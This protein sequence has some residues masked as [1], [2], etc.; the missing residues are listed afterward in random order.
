MV[1]AFEKADAAVAPIY[2]ASQLIEDPQVR[3]LDMVTTVEDPDLGPVRM[4]NVLFRMS[5]TPGEIRWTG[6]GLGADTDDV[7]VGDLG[8]DPD[9]VAEL[10]ERNV[11]A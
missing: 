11:V 7:L 10:R 1:E 6:R 3:A 8:M 2:D 5:E 4:Q 9:R